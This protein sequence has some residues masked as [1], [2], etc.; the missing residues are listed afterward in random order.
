M[1]LKHAKYSPREEPAVPAKKKPKKK[2][3]R[4]SGRRRDASSSDWSAI[5]IIE[6]L[7]DWEMQ[8]ENSN[9]ID[10]E[11]VRGRLQVPTPMLTS[12][13]LRIYSTGEGE[14]ATYVRFRLLHGAEPRDRPAGKVLFFFFYVTRWRP[15]KRQNVGKD[16]CLLIN[17]SA[18]GNI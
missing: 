17:S 11:V 15:G 6:C 4:P 9:N 8:R 1:Q 5:L 2:T 7:S 14:K 10:R 18:S 12:P 16:I 13:L 3:W